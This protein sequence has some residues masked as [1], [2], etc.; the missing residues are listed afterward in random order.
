MK[1][2][3]GEHFVYTTGRKQLTVLA[4]LDQICDSVRIALIKD[5]SINNL[6]VDYANRKI[7]E[8]QPYQ[9]KDRSYKQ[10]KIPSASELILYSND[11]SVQT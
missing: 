7:C 10:D 8:Y 6:V 11:L 9:F 4:N 3:I 1:K 2:D 5:Y